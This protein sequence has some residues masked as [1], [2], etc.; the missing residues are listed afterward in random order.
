MQ[1][2]EQGRVHDHPGERMHD[3]ERAEVLNRQR[4]RMQNCQ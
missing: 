3:S 1:N 4:E 2:C